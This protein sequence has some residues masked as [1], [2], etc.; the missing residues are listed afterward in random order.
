MGPKELAR[1][2]SYY[3]GEWWENLK[4]AYFWETGSETPIDELKEER[5]EEGSEG[6]ILYFQEK[7][8][9]KEKGTVEGWREERGGA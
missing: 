6:E 5:R 9:V 2:L 4:D 3:A 1:K 8:K 7:M